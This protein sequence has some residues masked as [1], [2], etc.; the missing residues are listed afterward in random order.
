MF[1]SY[2]YCILSTNTICIFQYSQFLVLSGGNQALVIKKGVFFM[3]FGVN[4]ERMRKDKHLSQKQLGDALGLTQ[5]MISSYEKG[6]SAPN[7]DVLLKIAKYFHKSL[8]SLVGYIPAEE[9]ENSIDTRFM[10]Y[11]QMLNTS[12]KERC[13]MIVQAIVDD[14]ALT[15]KMKKSKRQAC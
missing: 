15:T 4:L 6:S 10:S 14:R 11:Y 7:M 3:T 5:Q 9:Q 1:F 2:N 13:L 8:D 12:D